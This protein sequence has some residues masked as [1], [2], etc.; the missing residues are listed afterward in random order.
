MHVNTGS[1][2]YRGNSTFFSESENQRKA[3]PR[4]DVTT[5]AFRQVAHKPASDA[6]PKDLNLSFGPSGMTSAKI[7]PSAFNNLAQLYGHGIRK[8]WRVVHERMELSVFT[9]GINERR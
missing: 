4:S 5:F 2:G 7:K 8:N 9:A 3:D 1:L 6:Y